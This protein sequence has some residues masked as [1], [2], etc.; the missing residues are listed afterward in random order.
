MARKAA[1]K[2][3]RFKNPPTGVAVS[4]GRALG[5]LMAQR[6]KLMQQLTGV[7]EQIADAH[8]SAARRAD[9]L[10]PPEVSKATPAS[11]RGASESSRRTME[12]ATKKRWQAV[13]RPNSKGMGR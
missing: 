4:V 5:R 8:A 13:K 10:M 1:K 9:H 6:D 12:T 2:T 3:A 7:E 11:G